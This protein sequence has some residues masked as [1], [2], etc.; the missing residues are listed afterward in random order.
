MISFCCSWNSLYRIKVPLYMLKRLFSYFTLS[1]LIACWRDSIALRSIPECSGATRRSMATLTFPVRKQVRC[2]TQLRSFERVTEKW[3]ISQSL[4][5]SCFRSRFFFQFWW[6]TW[7]SACVGRRRSVFVFCSFR[8][9]TSQNIKKKEPSY[10]TSLTKYVIRADRWTVL[11]ESIWE[12]R[13]RV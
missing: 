11:L 9:W 6:W 12:R 13:S 10:F 1:S 8:R 2:I 7:K 4:S 5:F 3:D